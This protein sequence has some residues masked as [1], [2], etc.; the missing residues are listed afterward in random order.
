M[1]NFDKLTR[2]CDIDYVLTVILM[3]I[4]QLN[5]VCGSEWDKRWKQAKR[6]RFKGLKKTGK[7]IGYHQVDD[8]TNG[9]KT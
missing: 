2:Q 7:Q 4:R 8:E 5:S 3:H 9:K 6:E 1:I